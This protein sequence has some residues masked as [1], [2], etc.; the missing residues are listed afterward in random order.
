[1]SGDFEFERMPIAKAQ[2]ETEHRRI[3]MGTPLGGTRSTLDVLDRVESRSMHGQIPLIWD[4]AVDY[5][6]FDE[7]GNKWIDFTSTIFVAN[8][9]HSNAHLLHRL[10]EQINHELIASYAYP[11]NIR[12]Q[13]M[14]KL[15]EFAGPP[16]EK[17]FLLSAGTE[18][19]EAAIKLMRMN[20][21]KLKK[22]RGGVVVFTGNWHGRTLGAQ[23]LS[24]NSA[25]KDWI[26]SHDPDI[27]Y[28]PFPYP[29]EVDESSASEFF[30]SS[31]KKLEELGVDPVSDIC[32]F[33]LETFQGWGAFFYPITFV[34]RIREK[35]SSIGA[36]LC[37]DEMQAGFARTGKAFG[38]QHYG[39]QSD[40]ICCGKGMG[41]GFPLSGVIGRA[42]IM[43]LPSVGNMSSTH[44]GNP[45]A[46]AAGLAVIEEIERLD[47]IN[48]SDASGNVLEKSLET[49]CQEFSNVLRGNYGKGLI[50]SLVF[51][52]KIRLSSGR[53]VDGGLFASEVVNAS[54]QEGVLFVHTGRESIKLGPPLTIPTGAI[55]EAVKV[56]HSSIFR[57]LNQ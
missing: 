10:K 46:C 26:Y 21:R 37:F 52:D 19:T 29:W 50:R 44:S 39:V 24:S 16:F 25:Q 15:L 17:A 28:L 55:Q 14:K 3:N 41:G 57:V 30:D 51:R 48:K 31:F 22:R 18:T 45:L 27:F 43:D 7:F 23:Q 36:L 13:Y 34:K 54:F 6:I 53:I 2:I 32:G 38:F 11:V 12:A 35:S 1:M 4:R 56:L 49:L 33:M 5:N 9:G 8:I 40:L 42:E 20:G 47:L